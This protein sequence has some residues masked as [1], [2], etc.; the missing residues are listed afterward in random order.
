MCKY[1]EYTIQTENGC[2]E[3]TR[4]F[5]TDGYPR[6]GVKGNT[7]LK[8]H[9]EVFYECNGYYPDVVRH[10]CDNKKCINPDH[11]VGGT[12]LDNVQ[13]RNE[14]KRTYNHRPQEL[15]DRAKEL[16]SKGY[17]FK[18]IVQELGLEKVKQV[19]YLLR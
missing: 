4:C 1:L 6:A 10:T 14:R 13:D 15:K 17:K 3:W 16:R 8:V 2:L 9:R 11:L 5:N 18:E 7:N 12:S 19:E